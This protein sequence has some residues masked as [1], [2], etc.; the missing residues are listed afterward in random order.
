MQNHFKDDSA[1]IGSRP[2]LWLVFVRSGT[3]QSRIEMTQ[4]IDDFP[5]FPGPPR[6]FNCGERTSWF[7]LPYDH[8]RLGTCPFHPSKR[9]P[10]KYVF[11]PPGAGV[12]LMRHV[13]SVELG[14]GVSL[15]KLGNCPRWS[16]VCTLST[17]NKAS[18]RKF[19][20]DALTLLY[21]EI[22]PFP[23]EFKR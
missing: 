20:I 21:V 17:L 14:R 18:T 5:R 12:Q 9:L 3:S 15:N 11:T 10:G 19:L 22:L 2:L 16:A 6:S 13:C 1:Y 4:I 23:K 8:T 7:C